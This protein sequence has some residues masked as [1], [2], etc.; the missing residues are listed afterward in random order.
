[1]SWPEKLGPAWCWH[2]QVQWIEYGVW[3][4]TFPIFAQHSLDSLPLLTPLCAI[5]ASGIS[6][7][8]SLH[9]PTWAPPESIQADTRASLQTVK[10]ETMNTFG[11]T[12]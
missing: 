4:D 7:L 10:T 11:E 8:E 2:G 3:S 9:R 5:H 1:M 12:D 6:M